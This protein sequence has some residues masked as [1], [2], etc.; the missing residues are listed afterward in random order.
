MNSKQKRRTVK[1]LS[2]ADPLLIPDRVQVRHIGRYLRQVRKA[3]GLSGVAVAAVLGVSQQQLSRYELGHS[4]MSYLMLL[5]LCRYLEITPE[6]LCIFTG[7]SWS[8]TPDRPGN[9][10]EFWR[11]AQYL[12]QKN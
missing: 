11:D 4:M 10:V 3:L 1:S 5:R 6:E 2:M 8:E 9:L 7:Y 12:S